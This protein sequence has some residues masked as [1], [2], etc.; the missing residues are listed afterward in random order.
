MKTPNYK[1][2]PLPSEVAEAARRAA[3]AGAADHAVITVA[4]PNEAPCRHCLQW[5]KPGE[6][7]IL[8]PYQSVPPGLPYSESGPI[9]VHA[10]P[11]PRYAATDEYPANFRRHRVIRAYDAE[12]DMIDAVVVDDDQPE[13]VI[14]KLLQNP[15][16]AFLQARSVTRGCYTFRIE[17]A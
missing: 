3:K 10:E 9:F 17:R 1:V 16:T 11:C 7:V 8:F 2:V 5:A 15:A 4:S 12:Y 13:P 6:Q 14:E